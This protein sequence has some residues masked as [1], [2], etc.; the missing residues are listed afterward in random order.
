ML[1]T[2]RQAKSA[3]LAK[4]AGPFPLK[5]V[6]RPQ[7]LNAQRRRHKRVHAP[8]GA[9]HREHEHQMRGIVMLDE[10]EAEE[11]G[12]P[13]SETG[14]GR[15]ARAVAVD[16]PAGQWG[17]EDGDGEGDEDEGSERGA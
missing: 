6:H 7:H 5:L 11:D 1:L 14:G 15:Q 16:E 10:R 9:K 4:H 13:A 2:V 8:H 3:P 17:E 12:D